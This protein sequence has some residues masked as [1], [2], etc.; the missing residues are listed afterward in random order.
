LEQVYD[1]LDGSATPLGYAYHAGYIKWAPFLQNVGTFRFVY[2]MKET[3]FA[4]GTDVL[5]QI[6]DEHTDC[7]ALYA[8]IMARQKV[9]APT[10]DLADMYKL[11]M[12]Q[13]T[14]DVT[15]TDIVVFQQTKID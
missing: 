10:K 3:P 15:P 9:G 11:R 2:A 12:A 7:I 1:N 14:N 13:I 8:G 6:A 4:S 5:G